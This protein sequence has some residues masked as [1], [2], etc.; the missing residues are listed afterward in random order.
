[1]LLIKISL[2]KKIISFFSPSVRSQIKDE[3]ENDLFFLLFNL[4]G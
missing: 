3:D 1:V 2:D 4:K